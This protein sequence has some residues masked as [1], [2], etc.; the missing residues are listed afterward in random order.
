MY[1]IGPPHTISSPICWV[2]ILVCITMLKP[3]KSSV[4]LQFYVRTDKEGGHTHRGT[5]TVEP[6]W[7][8]DLHYIM[9]AYNHNRY[10]MIVLMYAVLVNY[11]FE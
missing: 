3:C 10:T 9:D 11:C 6:T 5:V 7:P 4:T 8:E 1:D 2:H